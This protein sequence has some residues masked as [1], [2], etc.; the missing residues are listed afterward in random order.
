MSQQG[1]SGTSVPV[2]ETSVY[3]SLKLGDSVVVCRV[4]CVTGAESVG[5]VSSDKRMRE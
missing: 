3:K 1:E 4:V 2:M 5:V